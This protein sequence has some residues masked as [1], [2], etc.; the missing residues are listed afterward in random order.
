MKSLLSVLL[1]AIAGMLAAPRLHAQ[2][3]GSASDL[4]F[5]GFVI[6]NEAGR[7]EKS[8]DLDLALSKYKQAGELYATLEK[9]FPTY[10]VETRLNRQRTI[11][12]AIARLEGAQSKNLAASQAA[13]ELEKARIAAQAQAQVAA[14]PM[15]QSI[16][17]P[18]AGPA[19]DSSEIPSLDGLLRGWESKMR[20]KILELERDKKQ[21]E[22]DLNKWGEWHNWAAGEMNRVT[23]E[24]ATLTKKA[25]AL[26]QAILG[27]QNEVDAGRA[28]STQLNEL[29][30]QKAAVDTE[31]AKNARQLA[32]AEKA[33]ADASAKL[34][35][36]TD[37]L[38]AVQQEKTKIDAEHEKLTKE[39]DEALK[40]RDVA[41]AKALGA[42]AEVDALKKKSAS[43]DMK[44]LIAENERLQ[45]EL[46]AAQKQVEGLKADVT[47]KEEE[48]IKLRGEVTTLQGQLTEMRQESAKYQT[49]VADLTRQL[50]ELKDMPANANPNEPNALITQENE[51]LRN[52]IMRQLRLQNRQQQAKELIIAQLSKM[53]NASADLLK[54][55]EELKNTRM[56]LSP[57]EE[58]LFKDPAAKELIGS[59]GVQATLIAASATPPSGSMPAPGSLTALLV[60]AGEAYNEK[61]FA[62]AAKLYDDAL[63][64]EP[65]SIDAL[66][67]LGMTQQRAGKYADSEAALQ[68]A[69]AYEP[70]NANAAYAMGVTHF[71]QERWKDSMTFFEKSLGK[72]PQNASARHYLGI[73]STKL[74]LVERAE[75]EFKTT[76]AIDPGH[77]EAH[78]NLAVLYATWDPPQWE[79]AREEYAA[80]LKKGV[81]PDENL[82]RLLEGGKKVSQN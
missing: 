50:K 82:E 27:M 17:A 48:I 42:Q 5:N 28:A 9:N 32:A 26:E 16:P 14:Q 29:K 13:V 3:T 78:F 43:G 15:P 66:I 49:Q 38:T 4:H 45:K 53:E 31:L 61:D 10:E 22:L 59:N 73:I 7:L 62:T 74:N 36:A 41:N 81:K 19:Q 1:L 47:R 23:G 69:M 57:D 72:T 44:K 75:R 33:A 24:N 76:L 2:A 21:L 58:K 25:V 34:K 35:T 80:A 52:I 46:A 60:R 54:Q 65:K 64:V 70:D 8:G 51:M 39:R 30:Q 56:T 63:R 55:V 71:K 77:G 79:K 12:T 68:K 20:G 67:G 37:S 18:Q 11:A 6:Y 40:Q